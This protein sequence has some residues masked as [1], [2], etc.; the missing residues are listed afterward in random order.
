MRIELAS[1][2]GPKGDFAHAYEPHEL[3]LED[4]WV[5]LQ[6]PPSVAGHIRKNGSRVKL[7]GHVE[8]ELEMECDRCVGLIRFPVSTNFDLEY[9]TREDYEAIAPAVEL[10]ETDLELSIFDGESI[11]IDELVREE[12]LLAV[13]THLLCQ[14][15]CKGVCSICGVDRNTTECE[16]ETEDGDPRW[17]ELKKLVN[18]K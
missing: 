16:C 3:D 6:T 9:V 12:L 2:E 8:A 18:G 1:L 17:A 11:D 15:N 7:S 13:P 5:R 10:S 14:E 4:E